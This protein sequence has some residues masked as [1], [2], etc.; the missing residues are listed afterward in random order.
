MGSIPI[1]VANLALNFRELWASMLVLLVRL[2]ASGGL[3]FWCRRG[4]NNKM[5]AVRN[6]VFAWWLLQRPYVLPKAG[7]RR[8]ILM[9]RRPAQ[10]RRRIGDRVHVRHAL[11]SSGGAVRR[12]ALP[13]WDGCRWWHDLPASRDG[14]SRLD[15]LRRGRRGTC[16]VV[17]R[18]KSHDRPVSAVAL[19]MANPASAGWLTSL[20]TEVYLQPY[21]ARHSA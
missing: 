3:R 8:H 2:P 6:R 19:G 20:A 5:P 21:S 16:H 1:G 13:T 14:A 11:V 7:T 10:I 15:L 17:R 12:R 4:W 9:Q 18:L